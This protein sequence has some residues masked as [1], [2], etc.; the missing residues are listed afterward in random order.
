MKVIYTT[1]NYFTRRNRRYPHPNEAEPD[2]F[3][4]KLLDG[5]TA[6]VT[7]LGSITLLMYFLTF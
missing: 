6:V 5:I 7:G 2:Y 3:I 1:Y 4:G